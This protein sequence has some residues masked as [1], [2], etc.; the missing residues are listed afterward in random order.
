MREAAGDPLE[1]GE[2]AVAAFIMEAIEG[3]AEELAVIH[4]KTRRRCPRRT[5]SLFLELFQ[6]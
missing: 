2:N 6:L 1:V 4:D 5:A 3:G